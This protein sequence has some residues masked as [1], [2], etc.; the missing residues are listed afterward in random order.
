MHCKKRERERDDTGAVK[1]A[2]D[3]DDDGDGF[4]TLLYVEMISVPWQ[5]RNR[6]R[7]SIQSVITRFPEMANRRHISKEDRSKM[8]D[9]WCLTGHTHTHNCIKFACS[10]TC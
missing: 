6:S 9:R 10:H 7:S 1:S 8:I 3:D 5:R 2:P 4:F